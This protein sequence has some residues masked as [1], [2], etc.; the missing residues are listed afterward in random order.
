MRLVLASTSVYRK[1]LLQRLGLDFEVCSPNTDE[2]YDDS[3]DVKNNVM[4]IALQKAQAVER[5]WPNALIIASDQLCCLNQQVLGKPHHHD[6]AHRQLRMASGQT[7]TFYT[8][9]VVINTLTHEI[10]HHCDETQVFF[11][12]LS[13]EDIDRYLTIEQP[14]DCAGS[15][16]V[17][18]LGISLFDK[19]E[20]Q[21][22]TAL[23]GLPLIALC[24]LL[25]KNGLSI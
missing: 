15:F 9:L 4:A 11:R 6:Q 2:H 13:D 8:A 23:V 19:V 24:G 7:V 25:R 5:Q 3:L 10:M 14:Y 21:D 1:A 17:E 12:Q 22:P 18:S 20:N 16:K